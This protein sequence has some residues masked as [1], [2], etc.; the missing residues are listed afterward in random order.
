MHGTLIMVQE[1]AHSAVGAAARAITDDGMCGCVCARVCVCVCVFAHSAVGAVKRA[2]TDD[3]NGT[4]H[5]CM[6]VTSP[7][8]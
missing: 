8:Q 3:G 2:I 6:R 4:Q 7:T 5:A 1:L